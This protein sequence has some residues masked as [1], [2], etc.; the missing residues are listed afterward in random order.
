MKLEAVP[1]GGVVLVAFPFTDLSAVK[2]RPALV[3]SGPDFHR[4]HRDAI[5]A[6]ISSVVPS[7]PAPTSVLIATADAEFRA[8]GL[9]VDSLVHCGKLVTIEGKL[10]LKYLGRIGAATTRKVDA[11]LARAVGLAPH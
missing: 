1:R 7:R 8:T 10:V 2:V 3:L 4:R 5:L 9:R 6:A 11:A